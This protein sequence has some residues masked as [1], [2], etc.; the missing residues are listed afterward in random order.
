MISLYQLHR[1][2]MHLITWTEFIIKWKKI[3]WKQSE[4]M[5]FSS[6]CPTKSAFPKFSRIAF[7][8]YR[9][10]ALSFLAFHRVIFCFWEQFLFYS[11]PKASFLYVFPS[12]FVCHDKNKDFLPYYYLILFQIVGR[13]FFSATRLFP[14]F[15]H[16][17][18]HFVIICILHH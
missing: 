16:I 12:L 17:I 11:S 4:T 2:C 13:Q 9:P 5:H 8:S 7:F 1:I 15:Y 18:G 3:I 10:T 14:L 6:I